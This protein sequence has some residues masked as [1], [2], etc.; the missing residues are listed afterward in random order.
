[1]FIKYFSTLTTCEVH[2]AKLTAKHQ[3]FKT[4]LPPEHQITEN[5]KSGKQNGVPGRRLQQGT[6][7]I[8]LAERTQK[9]HGETRLPFKQLRNVPLP[10]RCDWLASLT[11]CV[12]VD[13]RRRMT[14]QSGR[15]R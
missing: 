6:N 9:G 7:R 10:V 8:C 5:N 11:R 4:A 13:S 15:R 3:A 1:M 2:T 14:L 12:G